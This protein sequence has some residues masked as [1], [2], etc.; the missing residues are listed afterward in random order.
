MED[1]SGLSSR[2][3]VYSSSDDYSGRFMTNPTVPAE[4][5]N[6]EHKPV[7]IGRHCIVGAGAVI[8][9]GV[10]LGEGCAIAALALVAKDCASF[11]I[12]SGVPARLAKARERGLL[13]LESR[14]RDQSKDVAQS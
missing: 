10:T 11:G 3:A 12:Y 8:L 14:L 2:V 1:F 5:T 9:P 6:V 13:E 4:F 7:K